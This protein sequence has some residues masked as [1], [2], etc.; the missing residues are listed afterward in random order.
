MDLH[1]EIKSLLES[2]SK[3]LVDKDGAFCTGFFLAAEYVDSTGQ[4]YSMSISDRNMPPWRV[5]GLVEYEL[6]NDESE[7]EEVELEGGDEKSPEPGA[8]V[9]EDLASGEE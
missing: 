8:T 4:F 1:S 5:A 9:G 7:E 6:T 2:H 3:E